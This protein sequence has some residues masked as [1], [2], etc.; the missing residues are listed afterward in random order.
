M[1]KAI[2]DAVHELVFYTNSH[3]L[4][5][6]LRKASKKIASVNR[7]LTFIIFADMVRASK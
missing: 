6:L 4:F 5:R 3:A 2:R 7:N 1:K